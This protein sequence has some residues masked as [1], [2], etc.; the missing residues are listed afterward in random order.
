MI[1]EWLDG[2]PLVKELK[3]RRASKTPPPSFE[4]VHRMFEPAALAIAYAHEQGV[5]HRDIKPGNLFLQNTREGWR[6]KV[7]DFGMAKVL[8]PEAMGGLESAETLAGV[9]VLS[10]QYV[11]P[12]QLDKKLG[13]M[14]PWTDVYAFALILVE[15]L[16]NR[17][18]RDA[19][20]FADLMMQIAKGDK[21]PTPK[22]R[23]ADV[24]AAVDRVFERAFAR[25]PRARQ[26][27]LG[28]F[29]AELTAAARAPRLDATIHT[30]QDAFELKTSVDVPVAAVAAAA[31][32]GSTMVM[33]RPSSPL[34]KPDFNKTMPLA[35]PSPAAVQAAALGA[36]Q[37]PA[38][39]TA[40]LEPKTELAAARVA[41]LEAARPSVP[42]RAWPMPQPQPQPLA[43]VPPSSQRS[44]PQPASPHRLSPQPTAPRPIASQPIVPP[45]T[46]SRPSPERAPTRRKAPPRANRV[47]VAIL[48]LFVLA[49]FGASGFLLARLYVHL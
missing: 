12:E 21:L 27:N 8:S 45:S 16:T 42:E 44:T 41:A 47:M 46:P 30:D 15:A 7:L 31:S 22:L 3:D 13:P 11:T 23:G 37:R 18:A 33:D 4:E 19:E 14:G 35:Q 20:T 25:D 6:M 43:P 9:T 39:S 48:L 49:S 32:F 26:S 34:P 38:T 10:P 1:L 2:V 5:V 36:A 17:R 40:P 24:S 29:W 28:A